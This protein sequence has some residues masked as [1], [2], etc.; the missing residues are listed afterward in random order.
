MLQKPRG[1][2]DFLPDEMEARRAVEWRL[3]DVA[4]RWG[5]R[6][7]CTPEFEDL[8]LF[9]MRSGEGIIGEMYVFEDKGGRKLALRPEI[10]AAVIRMYIN[11]AKVAPKPLRWC[12]F[13]D[14]FRY[15]RPQK[16]RYR[17]FWQFG[18]ELIGADTAIADAEVIML[19][20]DM[21]NATGVRYE[22]K[23]GHLSFVKNLLKDVEPALQRTI[24]AQL[25]KKDFE[26]LK[27]TL[28]GMNRPELAE[29]LMTIVSCQDLK[30]AFEI[31]GD[32]PERERIE[33]TMGYLDAAGV[34]YSLN[35]GIA[36][37]LDYYT[38]IVFEGFADNLG[39]EN[40]IL[41]GGVYRLA[42]LFGGDDVASC[43]FAIGFDRVMV[44]LGET[45]RTKETVAA[46]VCTDEGRTRALA[47]ARAFRDAGIRTEMDLM[48]RGFGAQLGHAA[49]SATFAVIIGQRE[50][51]SGEVTL[52]NLQSGEQKTIT[53]E[54]ALAEVGAV[55]S[56]G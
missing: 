54:A 11:E 50:A 7:V 3:R 43:G 34:R 36:R 48:G 22:L 19:A 55:G 4:R 12:Y 31:A 35:L 37:G 49:K 52:K 14:C 2:R 47:V 15:E 6:E 17:Q 40:Q 21:L 23:V 25:D 10:T 1:T 18:V 45:A 33:Q 26:G 30:K 42:H 20:A 51:A 5:Y 27:A 39:A 56:R 9:T 24:R 28:D 53:L 29:S 44:S 16:G 13:A 38:G 32:I 8:E 46:I 41:G